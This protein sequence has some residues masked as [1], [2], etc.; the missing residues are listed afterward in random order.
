MHLPFANDPSTVSRTT[1]ARRHRFLD[2]AIGSIR[3]PATTGAIAPSSSH[4]VDKVV[5]M[6]ALDTAESV[7][8]LGPGTG[9]FTEQIQNQ[10]GESASF[11]ALELNRSFVEASRR[12]CPRVRVYHDAA[13]NLPAYL[14]N[15]AIKCDRIVTSLPWTIF[16]HHE[17][18][19]LL[20]IISASLKPGGRFISIVYLGARF[21]VR[22]RYF[23]NSLPLHFKQVRCSNTVWMNMPPTQ[24]FCCQN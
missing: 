16:E 9:A 2:F 4:V 3:E 22:G 21:R 13:E 20:E 8:E 1:S 5:A 18:D 14:A 7:V 11:F 17:Q 15:G 10:L 6:A 24:V 19:N 12:R 23:I